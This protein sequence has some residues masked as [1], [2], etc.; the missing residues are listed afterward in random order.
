MGYLGNVF[1]AIDQLGNALAGGNPDNTISA[2]IGYYCNHSDLN[3]WYWKFLN[4]IIDFTFYPIDGKNH[5]H[6]AYH[7]DAGELFDNKTSNIA[8]AITAIL[9]VPLCFLMAIILWILLFFGFVKPKSIDRKK[10]LKERLVLANAKLKGINIEL[11]EHSIPIDCETRC[12]AFQV[13][14]LTN[15]ILKKINPNFTSHLYKKSKY[16]H[17]DYRHK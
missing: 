17:F 12:L 16:L 7:N 9:V 5:C 4:K 11:N 6:E 14:Q 10:K 1:V 13:R 8:I 15:V 3:K 2:R